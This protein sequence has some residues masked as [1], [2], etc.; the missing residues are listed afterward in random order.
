MMKNAFSHYFRFSKQKMASVEANTLYFVDI[1]GE[2]AIIKLS[3]RATLPVRGGGSGYY[4]FS[5][6]NYS[7]QSGAADI[8]ATDI[9]VS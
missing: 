1:V 3:R 5:A 6:H 9:I 2:L 7:I 8:V 4:L